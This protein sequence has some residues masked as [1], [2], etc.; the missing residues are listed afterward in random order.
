MTKT[1]LIIGDCLPELKKLKDDSVE[2]TITSPPYN[3]NL[4]I[5][6]DKYCSRQITKEFSTK[7]KGFNDNLP[8][9]DYYEFHKDV[10]NELLRTT[11]G[12]IFYVIQPITGNKR[13]LFRLIGHFNE[14][15]KDIII[16]NKGFGQPAMAEKVMNS[17]FEFIIVLTKNSSIS[18]QFK[19][20]NFK[21][22]TLS[23]VWNIKKAN[24]VSKNH[25][26]TFPEELIN[27]IVLN[28][29]KEGD[30]ILDPFMGTGTTGVC[31]I[32]NNRKFFGIDVVDEYKDITE[33]RLEDLFTV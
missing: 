31:A 18:R 15:I 11:S 21:R 5:R 27:N 2:H 17:A 23:N 25:G 16:W 1:K 7:Y 6:K 28:F 29:T 32:K 3:M 10:L 4:R 30:T 13:A 19:D 12:N 8:M 26:A 14:Y 20:A 33:K 22:G 9:N 24:S